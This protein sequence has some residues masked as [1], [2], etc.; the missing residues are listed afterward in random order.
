MYALRI[1]T[2]NDTN[3]LSL[4]LSNGAVFNNQAG[5]T[6]DA[7]SNV[8]ISTQGGVAPSF[9]NAGTFKK[10]AATGTSTVGIAFNS[11]GVAPTNGVQ[12][13]NGGTLSLAGGGTSSGSFSAAATTTLSFGGAHTLSGRDRK[14]VV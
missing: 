12:V 14:S 13:L 4:L 3:G 8:N 5:A 9:N 2:W 11:T 1:S 7:Q 6:F 10:S